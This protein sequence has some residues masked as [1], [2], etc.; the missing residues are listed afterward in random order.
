MVA[1]FTYI[2]LNRPI[3]IIVSVF[4]NGLG[5]YGSIPGWVLPKIKK[6]VLDS[7]LPDTQYDKVW[8]KGKEYQGKGVIAFLCRIF[9]E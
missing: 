6:M 1:N 9:T 7:F 4:T 3:G 2:F 5:D 8:I